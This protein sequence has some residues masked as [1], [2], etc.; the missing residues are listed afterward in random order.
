MTYE[1][2]RAKIEDLN[3][4][5]RANVCPQV[6]AEADVDAY[7]AWQATARTLAEEGKAAGFIRIFD[8]SFK[9]DLGKFDA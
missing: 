6:K 8:G 3:A 2:A 9:L 7:K 1:A 5:I 4:R